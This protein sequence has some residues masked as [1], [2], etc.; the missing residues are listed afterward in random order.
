MW[1]VTDS[2]HANTSRKICSLHWCLQHRS[3]LSPQLLLIKVLVNV[4]LLAHSLCWLWRCA[5]WLS[6]RAMFSSQRFDHVLYSE[7]CGW[8]TQTKTTEA[9]TLPKKRSLLK[10]VS[11]YFKAF[12]S[13]VYTYRL[14]DSP[15]CSLFLLQSEQ[16][17]N[18]SGFFSH[19][20]T[21]FMFT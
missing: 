2:E 20:D 19:L 18:R 9:Y 21:L 16:E 6:V 1:H 5:S 14:S 12:L 10:S 11:N 13:N 15:Y 17:L 7:C 4:S 8:F 3:G